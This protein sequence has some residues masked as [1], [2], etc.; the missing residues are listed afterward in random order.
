MERLRLCLQQKKIHLIIR[1]DS[2]NYSLAADG[3]V[4]IRVSLPGTFK[5]KTSQLTE[6]LRANLL[7]KVFSSSEAGRI[8]GISKRSAQRFLRTALES[9]EVEREEAGADTRYRLRKAG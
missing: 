4:A 8:L 7:G 5:G 9:G 1:H 3:R 6:S 2:E